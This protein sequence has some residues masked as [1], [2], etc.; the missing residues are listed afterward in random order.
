LLNKLYRAG[1]KIVFTSR[2]EWAGVHLL[3]VHR[4]ISLSEN[5]AK[6]LVLAMAKLLN[7]TLY[8]S[9]FVQEIA[10]AANYHPRLIEWA[11]GK[12]RK[13]PAEKVIQEMKGLKSRDVNSL[14]DAM[15]LSSFRE[16]EKSEGSDIGD[17]LKVLSVCVGGITHNTAAFLLQHHDGD[18]LD[19]IL[20]VLQD[21]QFL[22]FD[23]SRYQVDPVVSLVIQPNT[24]F[25]A[26]HFDFYCLLA[27]SH[28]AMQD[29]STL[30]YETENVT[31]AFER[32]L[33][34]KDL[35]SPNKL[36]QAYSP[37]LINRGRFVQ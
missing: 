6:E 9:Q 7:I 34:A 12:M 22:R 8:I 10:V 15:V 25:F 37:Y 17:A 11:V 36:M 27:E 35:I 2:E 21:W 18:R 4:P 29:Y 20:I 14:L 28:L 24:N 16:M 19:S 3:Q 30:D 13:F 31:A 1:A 23:G 26:P 5:S 32:K 33:N